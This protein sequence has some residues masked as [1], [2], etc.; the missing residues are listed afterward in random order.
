ML[1]SHLGNFE[2]T[3]EAGTTLKNIKLTVFMHTDSSAKMTQ[4]L[5]KVNPEYDLT[6]IQGDQ[7]DIKTAIILKERVEQGEFVVIAG[8]RVPVKNVNATLDAEFLGKNAPFPIGPYVMAKV[9]QCPILCLFCLKTSNGYNVYFE[10]L[11]EHVEFNRNNRNEILQATINNYASIL[12]KYVKKA[13]LQWYN[14]HQFWN[15]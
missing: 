3:R 11:A 9:L 7:L 13:P 14:F 4:A 12:E 5:K 15:P 8:D 1:V 10:E 6:V 2:I